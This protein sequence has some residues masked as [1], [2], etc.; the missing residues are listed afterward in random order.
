MGDLQV[1]HQFYPNQPFLYF[2]QKRKQT[3][4][5]NSKKKT[6]VNSRDIVCVQKFSFLKLLNPFKF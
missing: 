4:Q 2:M 1:S 3:K 5:N 6:N